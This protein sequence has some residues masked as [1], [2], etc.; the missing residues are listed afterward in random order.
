MPAQCRIDPPGHRDHRV[1]LMLQERQDTDQFFRFTAVGNHQHHIN[2]LDHAKVAVECLARVYG[3]CRR[4]GRCHGGSDLLPDQSR[5]A[6]ADDNDPAASTQDN[7]DRL[8]KAPVDT[9][10]HAIQRLHLGGNDIACQ[11]NDPSHLSHS[12]LIS[13]DP[14]SACTRA[15]HSGVSTPGPVGATSNAR[16]RMP[17]ASKRS[18]SS[19]SA[20]SIIGCGNPA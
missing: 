1:L 14:I 15:R 16:I 3:K 11:C 8:L 18:C 12:L 5:L 6:H 20:C 19:F 13:T 2:G 7:V 4:P 17:A 10:R 9:A